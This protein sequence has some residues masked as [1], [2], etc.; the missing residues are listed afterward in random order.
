M[1]LSAM[2]M[3]AVLTAP[4][5]PT[6]HPF[7]LVTREMYP[8]LEARSAG[9]P[10]KE[11]K[12]SALA[13]CAA[14]AWSP[15]GTKVSAKSYLMTA[16]I[17]SCALS[18]ILDEPNRP[19]YAAKI[20]DN[21]MRWSELHENRDAPNAWDYNVPGGSAFFNSVLALDIIHD[22]LTADEIAAIEAEL[23]TV[24]DW[25]RSDGSGWIPNQFGVL[26]VWA[27]YRGDD[28]DLQIQI[29]KYRDGLLNHFTNEGVPPEGPGYAASR[30]EGNNER[31][32]K[33]HFMDVLEFNGLDHYY[34][35][36]SLA[37]FYEWLY[38][39]NDT[40]FSRHVS[41]GD[42]SAH[43]EGMRNDGA[44]MGRTHRI[45]ETAAEFAAWRNAGAPFPG[46][47][48][49]YLLMDEP[50]PAPATPRSRVF[51]DCAAAFLENPVNADSIYAM[52]WSCT[53]SEP[54]THKE[55]NAVYL[56]AYGEH[57]VRNS[58]YAGG[59]KGALGYDYGWINM[60]AESGNTVRIDGAD[61]D[62]YKK[63]TGITEWLVTG[64]GF[65]Y[66]SA[67]SGTALPNGRH[68]RNLVFVHPSSVPGYAVLFDEA[69][70]DRDGAEM[71]M[72]LHPN[73]DNATEVSGGAEYLFEIGPRKT[74][75]HDVALTVFYGTP[76]DGVEIKDGVLAEFYDQSIIGKYVEARFLADGRKKSFVTV[77]FPSDETHPKAQMS[78]IEG[79][80]FSG[81]SIDSGGGI[82]DVAAES[83]AT[84]LVPVEFAT[85]Q[86]RAALW[87]KTGGTLTF[88]FVRVG[89][90]FDDGETPRTGFESSRAV[91]IFLKGT[92]GTVVSEGATLTLHYPRVSAARIDG[93]E[94]NVVKRGNGWLTV[95]LPAGSHELSF[96][97]G[98]TPEPPDAGS[99]DT[100]TPADTG[101]PTT[102][103]AQSTETESSGCSCATV[104][105]PSR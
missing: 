68:T 10:W 21:L 51:P 101:A 91:S 9:T 74:G 86:G 80:G 103:A 96:E 72:D 89:K 16:V 33:T 45:S 11:M 35:E 7:L 42:T 57:V 41:I 19:A 31:D 64:L 76:P 54:H 67:D 49:H 25:F 92:K 78:R 4:A 88:Y 75:G 46:R 104:S 8:A 1:G 58:G 56:G 85:F 105:T 70:A 65:D 14:L 36:P 99:I 40:P 26:G 47:L 27:L 90:T 66:A 44:A 93:G 100:G 52:L 60:T 39:Y 84:G 62:L 79:K 6:A 30:F 53:K 38:G 15:E 102:D 48:I 5:P 73:A 18:Y 32:A 17:S 12:A 94:A 2:L 23:Q 61:H 13:D 59:G 81:A 22:Y 3:L 63:G 71:A 43:V 29:A 95:D 83:H 82:I 34:D 55:T 69:N 97:T 98:G 24:A 77:L 20:R 87:R 37:R 28:A 50:L